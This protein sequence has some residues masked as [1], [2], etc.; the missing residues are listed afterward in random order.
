VLCFWKFYATTCSYTFSYDNTSLGVRATVH[1][2]RSLCYCAPL[3]ESVQF[4]THSGFCDTVSLLWSHATVSLHWTKYYTAICLCITLQTPINPS[5]AFLLCFWNVYST[6]CSYHIS[7]DSTSPEPMLLC[8]HS[9]V[10]A[11][12]HLFL[13]LCHFAPTPDSLPLCTYSRICATVHLLW[14]VSL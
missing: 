4:C 6:T 3:L 8:T 13:S 11:T 1:T 12:V 14:N 2:L 9:G 5:K 7:Y 10:C